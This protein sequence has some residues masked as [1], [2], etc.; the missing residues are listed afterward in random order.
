MVYGCRQFWHSKSEMLEM[1]YNTFR[2]E[3]PSKWQ[4]SCLNSLQNDSFFLS[5]IRFFLRK[6]KKK[7][8]LIFQ[9]FVEANLENVVLITFPMGRLLCTKQTNTQINCN[10]TLVY[11]ICSAFVSPHLLPCHSTH[12][13]TFLHYLRVNYEKKIKVESSV[14]SASE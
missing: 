2:I 4:I 13:M 3:I 7:N 12:H 14:C 8:V 10:F 11:I 6:I 5:K 9:E 1:P